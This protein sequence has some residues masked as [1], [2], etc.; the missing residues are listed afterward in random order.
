MALLTPTMALISAAVAEIPSVF[1]L[2]SS[3]TTPR[4][5]VASLK[6]ISALP[7]FCVFFNAV[8]S[9]ILPFTSA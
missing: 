5:V 6:S 3:V 4:G 8:G 2:I 1:P 9:S 7:E